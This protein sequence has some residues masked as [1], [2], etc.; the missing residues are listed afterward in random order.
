MRVHFQHPV[1]DCEEGPESLE[2][3]STPFKAFT[4][5]V[6]GSVSDEVEGLFSKFQPV[7]RSVFRVSQWQVPIILDT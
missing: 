5:I 3:G 2:Y 6:C 1:A 7:L 4:R